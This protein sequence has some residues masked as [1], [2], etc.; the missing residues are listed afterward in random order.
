MLKNDSSFLLNKKILIVCHYS[1]TAFIQ[2]LEEFLIDKKIEK[3][4]YISHPLYPRKDKIGSFLR[5]TKKGKIANYK[6]FKFFP[7][8]DILHY[9]KDIF[10]TIWWVYRKKEEW[11]V[12][13]AADNLNTLAAIILKKIGLA[14]KV[15]FYTVDFV[16]NRFKN[17]FS[18]GFYHW[19][20]KYAVINAD[21]VWILSPRMI[22]GREKYLKLDKKYRD[23]QVVV[24]EGVWINRIKKKPFE[25][26]NKH[27]AIFVGHIIKRMGIQLVV[28]AIPSIIKKIPDFKFIVIGKGEY[29]TEL[30]KLAKKLK[31]DKYIE[32]K[33]YIENHKEVENIIASCGVGIAT[34]TKEDE[35]GLTFY[36]DPAKTKLYSGTDLPVIMTDTFYNAYD[37]EKAGGGVVV[38][39]NFVD[40]ANGIIKVIGSTTTL[41]KYRQ[42]ALEFAKEFDHNKLFSDNLNRVLQ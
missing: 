21:E 31:V 10:L 1:A 37:I 18:N 16:P 33:G 17:K 11:D 30:E 14:K 27:S 39:D 25:K 36:A 4:L 22:T 8:P 26:I 7:A 2:H 9:V 13:I 40:V 19:I 20:E 3:V 41:K 34:Y 28:E 38:G 6:T 15:V 32:F 5:L 35:S 12:C 23:K 24:P 42:D 29:R